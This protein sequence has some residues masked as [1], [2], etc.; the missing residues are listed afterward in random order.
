MKWISLASTIAVP[1]FV[2]IIVVY[3]L[4]KKVD[5]Y[6]AFVKG[7]KT[8]IST[9]FRVLPYVVGMIFAVDLFKVSG[10]F[11]YLSAALAPAFSVVGIPPEVLPLALMRP[12]SGG[13]SIGMLA[14]VLTQYGAD[15]YIGRVA[16]TF[17]G[18][19]ET[20]FY[21]VS[22]YFGSVGI[23]KTRYVVPVALLTDCFGIIFSC[24]ICTLIFGV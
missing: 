6:E 4:A 11:D 24:L 21:T 2:V 3:G 8:G 14:G 18:S 15:S 19:S 1:L 22:L 17:M 16:S 5:V 10:C 23:T 13:A 20:L 9:V 7:A 12:F